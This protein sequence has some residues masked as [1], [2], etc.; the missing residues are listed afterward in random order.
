MINVVQRYDLEHIGCIYW[1]DVILES[2][3][4]RAE[5]EVLSCYL[6]VMRKLPWFTCV[7]ALLFVVVCVAICAMRIRFETEGWRVLA[8]PVFLQVVRRHKMVTRSEKVVRLE[9]VTVQ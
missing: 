4:F 7:L 2:D 9:N 8:V 1:K 5:G 6:C 3:C